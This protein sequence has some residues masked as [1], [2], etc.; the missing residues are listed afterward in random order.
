MIPRCLRFILKA[1]AKE[2]ENRFAN[3]NLLATAVEQAIQQPDQIDFG[4][5]SLATIEAAPASAPILPPPPPAVA[6]PPLSD[7]PRT[8]PPPP[9]AAAMGQAQHIITPTTK[10]E[11]VQ[12]NNGRSCL[13]VSLF[14][15][16]ILGV[17]IGGGWFFIWEGRS[18]GDLTYLAQNGGFPPTATPTNTPAPTETST[19]TPTETETAVPIEPTEAVA[20]SD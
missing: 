4:M 10:P 19:V 16:I 1:L 7:A 2:P 11:K 15:L 6:G 9:A 8:L 14:F 5:F 13:F 18:F 20:G 3:G 12:T 17:A